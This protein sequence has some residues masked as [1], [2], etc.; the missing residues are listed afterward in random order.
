P[1]ISMVPA[2]ARDIQAGAMMIVQPKVRAV[3]QRLAR[4]QLE[5]AGVHAKDNPEFTQALRTRTEKVLSEVLTKRLNQVRIRMNR[6]NKPGLIAAKTP[7][8][9]AFEAQAPAYVIEPEV[10]ISRAYATAFRNDAQNNLIAALVNDPLVKRVVPR[11]STKGDL[12][13]SK[14]PKGRALF[15]VRGNQQ[16]I[17]RRLSKELD[18]SQHERFL[19]RK[20]GEEVDGVINDFFDVEG[21]GGLG[22]SE[23]ILGIYEVP[24]AY[25]V[26]LRELK[27]DPFRD[28][29][30]FRPDNP[31]AK[32]ISN[33]MDWN[34]SLLLATSVE[35]FAHGNRML[36]VM[37]RTESIGGGSAWRRLGVNLVPVLGP[38]LSGLA[39][40][41]DVLAT[42]EGRQYARRAAKI[43]A[44]AQRFL[45][46]GDEVQGGLVGA[47]VKRGHQSGAELAE[48]G[49]NF[50]FDLDQFG[51]KGLYGF[52]QRVKVGAWL[53][54]DKMLEAKIGRRMNDAEAAEFLTGF[55]IYNRNMT[56]NL[57][58]HLRRN[59]LNPFAGGQQGFIR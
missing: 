23:P 49:R 8:D 55:G 15:T 33:F 59:K 12:F 43:G 19:L 34:V 57:V 56:S 13:R 11:K 10:M 35:V 20:Q 29:F 28:K 2:L 3:A 17:E 54:V 40:A 24:K 42:A 1:F 21:F 22:K 39:T 48:A 41:F 58:E 5:R 7:F 53:N 31:L 37:S 50:L 51:I 45:K 30:L 4:R 26:M 47:L 36:G 32:V 18:I 14:P 38:R 16:I 44:T 25:E 27:D 52:D 46:F 9:K 6:D